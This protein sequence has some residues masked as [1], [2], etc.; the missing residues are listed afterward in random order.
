MGQLE[1]MRTIL[2]K[3]DVRMEERAR[4]EE[5]QWDYQALATIIERLFLILFL[6]ALFAMSPTMLFF[7]LT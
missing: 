6:I 5:N 2:R 1:E 7:H 4:E 3:M